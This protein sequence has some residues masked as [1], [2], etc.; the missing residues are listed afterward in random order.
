MSTFSAYPNSQSKIA[1]VLAQEQFAAE[2]LEKNRRR[3][4]YQSYQSQK[5][6]KTNKDQY[7]PSWITTRNKQRAV[8]PQ[9]DKDGFTIV[10]RR[11]SHTTTAPNKFT[12]PATQ[13]PVTKKSVEKSPLDLTNFPVLAHSKSAVVKPVLSGFAAAAQR[14]QQLPE[15]VKPKVKPVQETAP[16]SKDCWSDSEEEEEV[17]Q[18]TALVEKVKRSWWEMMDEEEE[19]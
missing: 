6:K 7:K 14:G 2:Q 13:K 11:G 5:N 17:M 8:H 15:P 4:A 18:F 3:I 9:Q 12:K 19:D 16:V 1:K 10:I